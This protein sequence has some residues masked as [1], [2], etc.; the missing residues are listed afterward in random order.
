MKRLFR[1]TFS[2]LKDRVL[3]IRRLTET[4]LEER[5]GR[6]IVGR[7]LSEILVFLMM[8]VYIGVFSYFTILKHLAFKSYAWDFGI[9]IQA[10]STTLNAGKLFYYTPELFVNQ[11]GSYFGLHFSPIMF[12]LLPV[13][14][15]YQTP[16]T[17][18]VFQSFVVALGALPLYYFTRHSLN[19]KL[20]AVSFSLLYLL[21]PPLQGANWFDFHVQTFLP[22]FMFSAMYYFE[23]EKW[24]KYFLFIFLAL[25]IA[26][27]VSITIIFV[28]LYGML[29]FRRIFFDSLK[30][31][32]LLNK[33][34]LIPLLTIMLALAWYLFSKWIKNTFFPINP[35]FTDFYNRVDW[36]SVLGIRGDVIGMPLYVILNPLRAIQALT[37]DAYLKLLFVLL[38]I[39]SLLFLPLR[40]SIILISLSWLV[41]ALLSNYVP[42]YVTGVH[43]PL[44][45]IPFIFLAAVDGMR[46]QYKAGKLTT[47]SGQ[48]KNLL[49]VALIFM[50]FASPLSPLLQTSGVNIPSFSTYTLPSVGDHESTLQSIIDLVP[51]N[52]SILTQNNIFP[53]FA[54]RSNAYAYPLPD[55]F[56]F[57]PNNVTKY[58]DQLIMRS[59]YV[60][61]DTKSD[62]ET[63]NA[64]LTRIWF[65]YTQ[66]FK[67]QKYSD[68][69]YLYVKKG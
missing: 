43:Y 30:Q 41:P 34:L 68:G 55:A 11:S 40:S 27:S 63:A 35:T 45:L 39:G 47:F 13:Y 61:V 12:L 17:L 50:L 28:G 38:L 4:E 18:L 22:L 10:L 19:S 2:T 6:K 65:T 66:T 16:E 5:L 48:I 64:I 59:D 42:F 14:A 15:V 24:V 69:I 20:A 62:A 26:E 56:E 23:K 29:K 52:A 60:L 21:Y 53:H 54:Q 1:T 3:T 51:S 8:L 44:Y 9:S 46:K 31:K 57:A 58:A 36:W 49:I 67:L 33:K 25:T 7:D 32:T 37:Y